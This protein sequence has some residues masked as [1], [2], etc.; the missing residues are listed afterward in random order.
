MPPISPSTINNIFEYTVVAANALRDIS[1]ATEIPFVSRV[2]TLTLTIIPMV[3]NT[4]FQKD[5]CFRIIEDIHHLLCVLMNLAKGSED[6]QSPWMLNHIAQCALT[7]QK[8]DSCLRAQRELGTFRRLF[9]QTELIAQ[10]DGCETDLKAALSSLTIKQGAGLASA[11]IEFNVD[12][13]RRHQELLEVI[14]AQSGSFDSMSSVG[15]GSLNVS[16]G[17]FSLL[18]ASPKIF[19]GREA[20]LEHL[21]DTLLTDP[22]RAAI[23][24][25][26]GMGK[27]TLA[28]AALHNPKVADKYPTRHFI[29]CDSS[30]TND[31][32]VATIASN[33]GV[34]A[35]R[36]LSRAVIHHLSTGPPCLVILDNFETPWEPADGRAEVEEFISLLTD[37]SH[38][39]LLITMR[40]AERPAK[41]R[42][43]HPFLPPL[44]PLTQTAAHQT[45]IEIADEIPTDSEVDQLLNIT[46]NIPLALQLVATAAASEGCQ[47]TLERWESE[48]TAMLSAGYDKRSNLE[49]SIM[50]SLS[51]PRILSSPEA[52]QLLSLMSLLSD[53]ISDLDLVQSN[54][55]IPEILKCKTTLVRTSLAYVDSGGRLKVLAPI[56][57]YIH[58]ARPPSPLL[59]RPLRK[60]L[61]DL[62]QVWRTDLERSSFGGNLIPRLISNLG[63]LHNIL[64]HALD[65]DQADLPDTIRGIISLN[66]LNLTMN[67]GL[68]PLMLRLPERLAQIE[69]HELHGQFITGAFRAMYV[70]TLPNPERSIAEGLEHF[71]SIK[72]LEGEARLYDCVAHY[73]LHRLGDQNKA[74]NFYDRAL[75]LASQCDSE[76]VKL[77]ALAGLATIEYFHGHYSESLRLARETHRIGVATGN[78]W[79]ELN[80][81]RSQAQCYVALGNFK[82]SVRLLN[83]AKSL[84]V[85]AGMKGSHNDVLLL[86][87]EAEVYQLKTEYTEARDIHKVLLRRTSEAG[88]TPLEHAYALLNIAFLDIVTGVSVEIVSHNLDA[89]TS[90]FQNM[91]Y[92]RGIAMSEHCHAELE[93]RE[94]DLAGARTRYIRLF[95]GQQINDEELARYSL[96]RL[97]DPTIPM[98]A[99]A[100]SARWAVVF[101][102]FTL[103]P[104]TRNMLGLYQ[105]LRCLGDVLVAQGLVSKTPQPL[106]HIK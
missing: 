14:S 37:V 71:R 102:A 56:R 34:E 40:G 87:T 9:K 62:L 100:E 83:N 27:T 23:L 67:H 19:H 47:A 52:V 73:Y 11:L 68:T 38:V 51:S 30:H 66:E 77:R 42:W 63:N 79:G 84:V 90:A 61:N 96:S 21:V 85:R 74:Q 60:H 75:S 50:L 18:P 36:R 59:V 32:L 55:P 13:E 12:I 31:S 26:G 17:S 48:R 106:Y 44:S 39:A 57:E 104:S 82:H 6:I 1:E 92:L 93:L 65:W 69:D 101:L 25:P 16:S 54:S 86:N 3:Q 8:V 64:L 29:P 94:G 35:S 99:T 15:Q 70:Y 80:G 4:K 97:A 45:F 5:R 95:T 105:A 88:V 53:G 58:N 91:H 72:D 33:L 2:C 98:H 103:R 46:D 49:L 22:A 24:G 78:L 89:A 10:L 28:V 7:L 41:V 43:T 76:V 20:E 81:I